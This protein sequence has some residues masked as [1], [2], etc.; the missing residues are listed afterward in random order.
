[1]IGTP[2]FYPKIDGQRFRGLDELI[3]RRIETIHLD[4][5]GRRNTI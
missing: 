4:A 3:D 2:R 5:F 1:M